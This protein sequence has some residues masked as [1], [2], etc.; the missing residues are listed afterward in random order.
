MTRT[1]L[2]T[3]LVLSFLFVIVLLGGLIGAFGYWIIRT[4]VV[5]RAQKQ[6]RNDL[7][8][9]WSVYLNEADAMKRAFEMLNCIRD[10][11]KIKAGLGLDYLFVVERASA[12][13]ARS[14]LAA[15]AF[16]GNVACGTRIIDSAELRDIG[17]ELFERSRIAV[18]PTPQARPSPI[19][20]LT[21]AMAFE[22]AAPVFDS[23]GAVA[24]VIYGGKIINRYGDLIDRIH[25]MVFE[26]RLYDA[27]PV[28]T[29]TI[30]QDDIRI[31]T[32]VLDH[33]G[34]PAIGTRVSAVVYHHVV[35]EGK[36]WYAPAFVVTGSYLTAYEPIRD[37]SGRIVGILYVGALEAPFRDMVRSSAV[38]FFI[39]IG[40]CTLLAVVIALMLAG[41]I[42]S[43]LTRLVRATASLA[44]GDLSHRVP[45]TE[46]VRE[47]HE[48]AASFNAM[49]DRLHRRDAS[50][51]GANDE[52]AL[53]NKRYLDL[54]G[55]VSHELKGIL[56]STMLNAYS[57]RDGHFGPLNEQQTKALASVTRN[58]D[59]FDMTVKNFLNLS[60][61]EK[62]E[63]T[64][65][66]E[67][68][69]L[70]DAIVDEAVQTFLPQARDRGL[71]I[72]NH[73]PPDMVV[74]ADAAQLLMIMNNLIG[75]A[76]KYGAE[77]GTIAISAVHHDTAIAIEVY[78]DGRPLTDEDRRKIFQRFSRLSSSPEGKRT[79]G[80]GLGLFICRQIAERHGG[81]IRCEA[82]EA[83][84]AF[85]VTLPVQPK[86]DQ[87]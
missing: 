50:L 35:E 86:T 67:D 6:L 80:T 43:P 56:S 57:V 83:G 23:S 52:L 42:S 13:S 24:R 34:E 53:L 51:H 7:S 22:C 85:I 87:G 28:G 59:Y 58:L 71:T 12:A 1:R 46:R 10:P 64:L 15:K 33:D 78:N 31:A 18:R 84:N 36:P 63:F 2:R 8:A 30:F 68:L 11:A 62:D 9:A 3:R 49:A 69:R 38:I 14:P 21:S 76:I 47:L 77:K 25:R 41:S 17:E 54:V 81:A 37:I 73:I 20:T 65:T 45:N 66:L 79:R 70:K 72:E 4:N 27:K 26:D 48:L 44:E 55:I 82:R 29:V 61:I 5:D 32:N 75:N 16:S 19:A 40:G 39:I 74:T 60:R